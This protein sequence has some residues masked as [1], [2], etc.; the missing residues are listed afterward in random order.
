MKDNAPIII[1][2]ITFCVLVALVVYSA[3]TFEGHKYAACIYMDEDGSVFMRKDEWDDDVSVT[4][5]EQIQNTLR[6][7]GK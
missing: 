7:I 2:A 3:V 5:F 1:L 4:T 6:V